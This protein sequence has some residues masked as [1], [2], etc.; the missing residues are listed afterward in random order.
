VT[1]GVFCGLFVFFLIAYS[2]GVL[3]FGDD[4][5]TQ[6][7]MGVAANISGVTFASAISVLAIGGLAMATYKMPKMF[8]HRWLEEMEEGQRKAREEGLRKGREEGREEFISA[9]TGEISE[10]AL[11]RIKE[12]LRKPD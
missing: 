1:G 6:N 9:A 5:K 8:W 12:R 2:V 7:P 4:W 11:A 3:W 10:E